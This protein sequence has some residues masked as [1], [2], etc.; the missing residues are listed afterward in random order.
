MTVPFALV[1]VFTDVPLAG[2]PLAVVPHVPGL[3]ESAM[4]RLAREFNQSET[5]FLFPPTL[6]G[7]DWLLRS[8]TPTGVEVYGAGHNALGA[9]WWL[10]ETG[11]LD[12]SAPASEFSQQL[13]D[14]ALSLTIYAAA[15]RPTA[16]AMRQ[17]AA[18]YG[19]VAADRAALAEALGVASSDILDAPFAPQVVATDVAHLLV[20]VRVNA[21]PRVRPAPDRL[22]ALVSALGGEGCYVFTLDCR[23]PA[24][25][26]DARFFNPGVGIAEDPATGTAAGPLAAALV[27]HGVTGGPRVIIDQGLQ[28]GRPSRLE[29]RV[30]GQSI[31]LRGAAVVSGEGTIRIR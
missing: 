18:T 24:A 27:R 4:G 1:D 17:S 14:R 10:A 8:F 28:T 12:L 11:L 29:I 3:D 9:W 7:A 19:A 6:P 25:T 31:E 5:T 26:A 13:G 2:N 22:A 20:P 23:V 30:E 16:V 21:L 15:G